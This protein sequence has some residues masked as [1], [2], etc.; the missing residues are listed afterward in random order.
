M[1]IVKVETKEGL[2]GSVDIESWA[3]PK[4]Q[5][6]DFI[7]ETG[8]SKPVDKDELKYVGIEEL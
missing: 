8:D 5:I 7:D 4:T 6:L 1:T 3:N 2:S